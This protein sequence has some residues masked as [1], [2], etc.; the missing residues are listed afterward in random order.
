MYLVV[1]VMFGLRTEYVKVTSP[2]HAAPAVK[3]DVF[4]SD[5]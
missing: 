1:V 5:K 2:W 3:Q 4:K